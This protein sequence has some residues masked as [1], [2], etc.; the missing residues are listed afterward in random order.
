M[1]VL[2]KLIGFVV[3]CLIILLISPRVYSEVV[4]DD[5]EAQIEVDEG[6]KYVNPGEEAIFVWFVK[7]NDE[8]SVLEFH[9]SADHKRD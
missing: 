3:G 4:F 6:T 5:D 8:I 9:P 2:P 7:N 1:H